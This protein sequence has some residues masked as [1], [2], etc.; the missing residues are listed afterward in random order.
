[1][2]VL[3]ASSLDAYVYFTT[4]ESHPQEKA[5]GL[6][7]S[8]TWG[9]ETGVSEFKVILKHLAS[10]RPAWVIGSKMKKE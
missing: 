10:L 1:M 9:R 2:G 7:G 3:S 5:N 4:I 6:G 8:S